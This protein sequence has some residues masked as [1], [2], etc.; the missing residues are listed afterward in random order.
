MHPHHPSPDDP[1]RTAGVAAPPPDDEATVTVPSA[2]STGDSVLATVTASPAT[3]TVE[4]AEPT[5][6]PSLVGPP[7]FQILRLID[8]GGMGR[9][10]LARDVALNRPVALKVL[11]PNGFD[12]ASARDRFTREVRAMARIEHPNLVPVYQTGEFRGGPYFT[13]KYMT[14]GT[15]TVVG[16]RPLSPTHGATLLRDI[17]RGVG[18]L[19]AAGILHRDLK[20]SNILLD[21]DGVP[22]VADFG[23]VKWLDAGEHTL[24]GLRNGTPPYMSPE[25]VLGH[26]RRLTPASD[27]WALGVVGYELV[28]GRRPFQARDRDDLYDQI[29]EAEP[30]LPQ[31]FAPAVPDPLASILLRCLRK[32]PAARY[33][34]ADALADDLDR[35]LAGRPVAASDTV[36]Q[37][38]PPAVRRRSVLLAGVGATVATAASAVAVWWPWSPGAA[39]DADP[40]G[41]AP[42][43][44]ERVTADLKAGKTVTL[45]GATGGPEWHALCPPFGGELSVAAEWPAELKPVQRGKQ[46]AVFLELF[47]DPLPVP[48]RLEA[49]IQRVG[50]GSSLTRFGLYVGRRPWATDEGEWHTAC[51]VRQIPSFNGPDGKPTSEQYLLGV[52]LD[53]P[54]AMAFPSDVTT[55]PFP[56]PR[57]P[58]A[59]PPV[60]GEWVPFAVTLTPAGIRGQVFGAPVGQKAVTA[61][62][63]ASQLRALNRTRLSLPKNTP[64]PAYPDFGAVADPLGPGLGI[65]VRAA[66]IAV[67]NVRLV[68]VTA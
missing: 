44:A 15:L 64:Q 43:F 59:G 5:V 60:P 63:V 13:M 53:P 51:G 9:V 10:Y 19:H 48:V 61:R 33:A 37:T 62:S 40:E 16:P 3:S 7:G 25:Q 27:V 38:H 65:Y 29:R 55:T 21:A 66:R 23:L 68:P 57:P 35:F 22:H 46:A 28:A 8:E 17:A 12:E 30:D 52:I 24:S 58:V 47:A 39:P 1:T 32:S 20:P 14:G 11:K 54:P 18:R 49:D 50:P 31:K 4:S 2:T 6:T 56:V 42:T 26:S 41:K 34:D 36:T 67:R 45:V